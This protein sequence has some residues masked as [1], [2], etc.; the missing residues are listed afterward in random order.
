MDSVT[1]K[2]GEAELELEGHYFPSQPSYDYDTPDSP[3]EF[4]IEKVSINGE[5]IGKVFDHLDIW[6]DLELLAI[7]KLS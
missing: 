6:E 3:A 7:E 5:D 1:V 2:F 4:N